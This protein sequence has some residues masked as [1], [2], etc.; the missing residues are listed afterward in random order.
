M[1]TFLFYSF[2]GAMAVLVIM[3]PKGFATAAGAVTGPGLQ[4][5]KT[6]TGAGY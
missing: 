1:R 4:W 2:I 6:L 3:N 5:E